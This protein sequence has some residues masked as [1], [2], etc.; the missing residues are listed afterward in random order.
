MLT[1]DDLLMIKKIV[2]DEIRTEIRKEI[3]ASEKRMDIR[4]DIKFEDSERRL[5]DHIRQ[6][7]SAILTRFDEMAVALKNG[8]IDRTIN[9]ATIK[10]HQIKIGD[11]EKRIS[12]LESL[13]KKN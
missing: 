9:T 4:M 7:N 2:R 1:Q 6:E 3:L 5:K 11:H 8:D 12:K 13:R 10:S